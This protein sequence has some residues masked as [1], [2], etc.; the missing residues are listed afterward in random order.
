LSG[1][2]RGA[3]EKERSLRDEVLGLTRALRDMDA[4]KVAGELFGEDEG[5][6]E[7][8]VLALPR[9]ASI[10]LRCLAAL[11][12]R[13]AEMPP[14]RAAELMLQAREPLQGEEL[15]EA[16]NAVSR[17]VIK[18]HEAGPDLLPRADAGLAAKAMREVDYGKLRKALIYRVEERMGVM[19]REV[20]GLG[21]NPLALVNLFSVAAP[22]VNQAL[23]VLKAFLDILQLPAEAMTFA[24]W[25]IIEDIDWREAAGVINGAAGLVVLL[26]RG[27]LI[28]G[29]GAPHS[30]G[31]ADR[32]ASD[33]LEGLDPEVLAEALA[34]VA[35]EAGVLAE[36]LAARVLERPGLLEEMAEAAAS[37]S[38]AAA[39]SLAAVADKAAALPPERLKALAGALQRGLEEGEWRKAA[40][41]LLRLSREVDRVS[42]GLRSALA[43][44]AWAG[45]ELEDA[46]SPAVLA[47]RA[48]RALASFNRGPSGDGGN[49][50]AA[51]SRFLEGL[52]R[53]ELARAAEGLAE[54][55]GGVMREDPRL[56]GALLK[57]IIALIGTA[58]RSRLSQA[59]K[60][61]RRAVKTSGSRR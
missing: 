48:N 31:P 5:F 2:G 14:Q 25:K 13:L 43:R 6:A 32:I 19:R 16:V 37:A 53:E 18:M 11:A 33:L 40:G 34:A 20:E 49:G 58:V 38:N 46:C 47:E 56:A 30:R 24:L 1:D 22:A 21:E 3:A 17:L 41:S 27:N 44:E 9:A 8:L 26:H 60:G 10:A 7:E 42:P 52:D 15:A 45:L 55:A 50:A 39:G 4:R 28:L 51:V 57:A 61:R 23:G 59:L 12:D 36:A 35:E 54:R 29:N